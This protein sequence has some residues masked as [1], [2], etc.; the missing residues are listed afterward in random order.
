MSQGKGRSWWCGVV[1]AVV[2]AGPG[3]SAVLAPL[4]AAVAAHLPPK[5]ATAR[6]GG[7]LGVHPATLPA[8]AAGKPRV[9]RLS[10]PRVS[11]LGGVVVAHR[12]PVPGA[13]GGAATYDARKGAVISGSLVHHR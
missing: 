10:K 6:L 11:G 13:V 1:T 5:V 2:L 9:M 8:H 4:R 7:A 3:W 12:A